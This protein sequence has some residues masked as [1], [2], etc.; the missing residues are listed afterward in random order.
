[1][2]DVLQ[3]CNKVPGGGFADINR[4]PYGEEYANMSE[5]RAAQLRAS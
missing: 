4:L 2:E 3:A 5:Y 1:M